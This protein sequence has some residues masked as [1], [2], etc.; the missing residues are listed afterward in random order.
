MVMNPV[1]CLRPLVL[2]AALAGAI[3]SP[4]LAH[5][6]SAYVYGPHV[7]VGVGFSFGYPWYGYPAYPYAYAP[8]YYYPA[9]AAPV[10]PYPGYPYPG[11]PYPAY[12]YPGYGAPAYGGAPAHAPAYAPA[13]APVGFADLD[14]EPEEAKVYVKGALVGTADDYD[15]WPQY[16][17][18]Q[19]GNRTVV[20]K[21]PGYR[22]LTLTL[23]ITPG[24]VVRVRQDMQPLNGAA[25]RNR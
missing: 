4:A 25:H 18:L 1:R 22:D 15:G 16:L 9:Y 20:L 10:Y 14:V 5:H 19:A 17:P 6:A 21:H 23:H 8:P 11:Y 24:A 12:V 2:S 7:H 3:W 13:P